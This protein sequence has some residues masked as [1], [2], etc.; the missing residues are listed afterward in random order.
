MVLA[1]ASTSFAQTVAERRAAARPPI[2]PAVAK[3]RAEEAAAARWAWIQQEIVPW[4]HTDE[5]FP[6]GNVADDASRTA[7]ATANLLALA[8]ALGQ[9]AAKDK[10]EVE[11]FS[12]RTGFPTFIHKEDGGVT[13]IVRIENGIPLA[14]TT[15]NAAAADT[16]ST[17]ELWPG[18]STGLSLTGTNVNIGMWDGGDV[19]ISHREFSTNGVRVF[20]IDGASPPGVIDH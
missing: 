17:D 14:N 12:K 5:R 16:V 11:E 13:A 9:K 2:D 1:L 8:D 7:V 20:D 15:Q 18:G 19:R 3:Q 4:L 10:E 6:D